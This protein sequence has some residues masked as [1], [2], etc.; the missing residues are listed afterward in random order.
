MVLFEL[1]ERSLCD[2]MVTIF[3]GRDDGKTCYHLKNVSTH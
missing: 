3:M 1:Y 2:S